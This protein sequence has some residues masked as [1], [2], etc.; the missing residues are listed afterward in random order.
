[1]LAQAG[2]PPIEPED[3]RA[4][5]GGIKSDF[6]C[7]DDIADARRTVLMH[8]TTSPESPTCAPRRYRMCFKKEAIRVTLALTIP[9]PRTPTSG[10][11][12]KNDKKS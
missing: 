10:E 4:V 11:C 8:L 5:S 6:R 2:A 3:P 7:L 12:F 1:M 9:S